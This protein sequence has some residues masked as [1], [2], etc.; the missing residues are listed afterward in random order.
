MMHS[1]PI[2]AN[3]VV[4]QVV[5]LGFAG[6]ATQLVQENFGVSRISQEGR[7]GI[8][9]LVCHNTI[10]QTMAARIEVKY[11]KPALEW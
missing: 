2:N 8:V 1:V 7:L 11:V 5:I 3:Q 4:A 10:D 9:M 6:N